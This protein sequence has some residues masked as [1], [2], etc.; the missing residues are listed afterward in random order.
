[1]EREVDRLVRGRERVMGETISRSREMKSRIEI[2]RGDRAIMN[3]FSL[4]SV[5]YGV[6]KLAALAQALITLGSPSAQSTRL[7]NPSTL[8]TLS[9]LSKSE[10]SL[11]SSH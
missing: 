11:N 8:S 10:R 1:L 5:P 6:R 4:S 2:W 7:S 3:Q 9:T